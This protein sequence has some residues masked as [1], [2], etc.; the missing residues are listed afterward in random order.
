[1]Y[2]YGID[3]YKVWFLNVVCVSYV[4]LDKEI[5]FLNN[6]FYVLKANTEYF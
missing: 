2:Q 3:I 6:Q 4:R 1:M 5:Y